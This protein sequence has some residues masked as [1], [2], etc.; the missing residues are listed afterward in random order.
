MGMC[1]NMVMGDHLMT[2]CFFEDDLPNAI[3]D[4]ESLVEEQTG[5]CIAGKNWSELRDIYLPQLFLMAQAIDHSFRERLPR[6]YRA[7]DEALAKLSAPQKR[8]S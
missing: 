3:R 4:A 6:R 7:T 2:E 8:P 1:Y 5:T